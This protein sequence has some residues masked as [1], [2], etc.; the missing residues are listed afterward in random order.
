M[1]HKQ[2]YMRTCIKKTY[3][4][5]KTHYGT[6]VGRELALYVGGRKNA[7]ILEKNEAFNL[8]NYNY[9]MSMATSTLR[10]LKLYLFFSVRASTT[11]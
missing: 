1:Y 4:I 2:L 3:S 11:E 9:E 5:C 8:H 10:K 6:S 7:P